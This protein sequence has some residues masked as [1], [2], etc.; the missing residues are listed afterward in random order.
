MKPLDLPGFNRLRFDNNLKTFSGLIDLFISSPQR[1]KASKKRVIVKGPLSPVEI[2]FAAGALP[3]DSYTNETIWHS[4]MNETNSIT[5]DAINF[6]VSS[7][8]SSWN[9]V[10]LGAVISKL[11]RLP[12]D[13]YSTACGCWDDQTTKSWQIMS[14]ATSSPLRFWEIPR[15]DLVTEEW[16]IDYLRQ[17]L[18]QLFDWMTVYTGQQVTEGNLKSAIRQGNMLRQD[19]LDLTKMLQLSPVPISALEYYIVQAFMGDY[20]QDPEALHKNYRCLLQELEERVAK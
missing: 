8:F 19:M 4:V 3:Y 17:E 13:I 11:N 7:D 1:A 18:Q 16:A 14:R 15:F 9:L 20:A 10:M 2:I 12:L 6:G 5:N